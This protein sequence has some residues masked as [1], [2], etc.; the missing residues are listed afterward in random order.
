MY[1]AVQLTDHLK[2]YLPA[3]A[4]CT[5]N[6]TVLTQAIQKPYLTYD[7]PEDDEGFSADEA[8]AAGL[9]D[10]DTLVRVPFPEFRFCV[11]TAK[12]GY[13][14]GMVERKFGVLTFVA[15]SKSRSARGGV[16]YSCKISKAELFEDKVEYD[17]RIWDC[18]TLEDVTEEFRVDTNNLGKNPE[19]DAAHQKA[20]QII[21]AG[22]QADKA[23]ALNLA[24]KLRGHVKE[25]EDAANFTEKMAERWE[26]IKSETG[27]YAKLPMGNKLGLNPQA[28]EF[29]AIFL[30]Y[31]RMI[32]VICYEYLAPQNFMAVV[33]P[34]TP[35]KSVEWLKAREHI[36]L[37]HRHHPANNTSVKAG[38]KLP[39]DQGKKITRIAHSRR[40]HFKILR[41]PR[42]RYKVGQRIAINA[43]WV[44]PKQWKDTAGQT[45]EILIPVSNKQIP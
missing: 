14:M 21:E 27:I 20:K 40:A 4:H 28:D 39:S 38:E 45:Y 22:N 9:Y 31:Y 36:T 5:K 7:A 32:A 11:G 10:E 19:A 18:E 1:P 29:G 42:F 33:R 43:T 6:M 23:E 26:F 37:I 8:K 13:F 34:S 16:F 44:G 35:G 15:F 2:R 41:S 12:H 24:K 17:G 3:C 30:A 25:L